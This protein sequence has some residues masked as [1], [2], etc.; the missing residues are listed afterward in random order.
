MAERYGHRVLRIPPYHCIFN[1]IEMVWGITK[2][3]YNT[4]IGRDGYSQENCLDM[5]RESLGT[6]TPDIWANCIRHTEKIIDEWFEKEII[7]DQLDLSPIII[8]VNE[9]DSE[10]SSD[11]E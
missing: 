7:M 6:V 1:A 2:T 11:S 10:S 9:S 4:H 8:N 3:Y 5:W